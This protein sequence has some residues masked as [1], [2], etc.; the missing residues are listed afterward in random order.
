MDN[1]RFDVFLSYRYADRAVV[2]S[3][4]SW[5]KGQGLT[6]WFDKWRLRPGLPWQDALEEGVRC[7][8]SIAVFI[9]E[10]GLGPWEVPE[11]RAALS[12]QVKRACPVI[13]I[14]LPG[15]EGSDQ[16]PMFLKAQQWI[17]LRNGWP[18]QISA[19]K[20]IWGITGKEPIPSIT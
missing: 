17:D 3:I 16:L 12:E 10:G 11:M 5:L 15:S 18:D 14:F 13:P 20:L 1:Q 9:G 7:S 8:E 2:E 19:E 4:A 6:V